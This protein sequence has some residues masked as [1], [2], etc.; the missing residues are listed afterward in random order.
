MILLGRNFV[1]KKVIGEKLRVYLIKPD[2]TDIRKSQ[3]DIP[4]AFANKRILI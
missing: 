3:A 1:V 2:R 4:P